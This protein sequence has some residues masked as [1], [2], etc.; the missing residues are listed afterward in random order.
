[1]TTA[2]N[3][4]EERK[5]VATS[6]VEA[7]RASLGAAVLDGT[8][9][10]ARIHEGMKIAEREL[11]EILAAEGESV[12]R[13]RTAEAQAAALRLAK[14]RHELTEQESQRLDAVTRA[15]EH[16]RGFVDAL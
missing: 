15:E 4:L 12:R 16:A 13:H 9:D 1:M 14:L 6:H 3:S 11:S 5:A 8:D 10:A 2:R 7:L